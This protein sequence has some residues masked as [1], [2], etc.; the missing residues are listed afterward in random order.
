[1]KKFNLILALMALAGLGTLYSEEAAPEASTTKD[2]DATATEGIKWHHDLQAALDEAKTSN[3]LV[4]ADFTGSD[5]C[6]WCIKLVNE[7]FSQAAF[8]N[9]VKDKYVFAEIDVPRS[10]PISDEQKAKNQEYIKKYEIKG[11]PSILILKADGSVVGR[12][13]YK[14]GGPEAYV[15]HLEE[16]I[17][18]GEAGG[19]SS[20]KKSCCPN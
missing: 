13:G 4:I 17:A 20:E 7:V 6:G 1:M 10:K 2:A 3:K 12:T 16:V 11:F 8:I 15:K 18:Q 14:A 9:A 19:K 5:W